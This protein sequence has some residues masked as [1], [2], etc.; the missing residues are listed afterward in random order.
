M[1]KF[2]RT[3]DSYVGTFDVNSVS[4]MQ[5]LAD[6]REMVCNLNRML[7][8]KTGKTFRVVVRGRR[9]LVK[10][11]VGRTWLRPASTKPLSYDFGGNIVGGIAN[12]TRLDAYI[13]E[14]R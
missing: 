1:G 10:M 8:V 11:N 6:I 9:P 12:A 3:S 14:R 13:Y 2:G 5:Q 7:K 4:D